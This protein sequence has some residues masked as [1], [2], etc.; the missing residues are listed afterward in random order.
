MSFRTLNRLILGNDRI[1][2]PIDEF[3]SPGRRRAGCLKSPTAVQ[4]KNIE[5]EKKNTH[6]HTRRARQCDIEEEG[7]EEKN[8]Y[9]YI[10]ETA[11][12]ARGID[13]VVIRP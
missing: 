1:A 4:K 7:E 8:I 12:W 10:S 9:I 11:R 3:R 6:E 5:I 13:A 2:V